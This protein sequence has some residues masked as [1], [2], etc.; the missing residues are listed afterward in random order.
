MSCSQ[1][2]YI[3]ERLS[4]VN[5][6]QIP[7]Y[8]AMTIVSSGADE[9]FV[10]AIRAAVSKI[11]M[12]RLGA[13]DPGLKEVL[14][15]LAAKGPLGAFRYYRENIL[16]HIG[17]T[18][19]NRLVNEASAFEQS[20]STGVGD[21]IYAALSEEQRQRYLPMHMFFVS[22]DWR[23]HDFLIRCDSMLRFHGRLGELWF[24]PARH[25]V[26][27]GDTTL[28]VCYGTH[29]I[30]RFMK[31]AFGA[32][33]NYA[34]LAA[35]HQTLRSE[36]YLES[37]TLSNGQPGIAAYRPVCAFRSHQHTYGYQY[38]CQVA[39]D[40]D[41][42]RDQCHL[43]GYCPLRPYHGFAIASTLLTPGFRGT[44]EHDSILQEVPD[45][46]ER[47]RMLQTVDRWESGERAPIEDA[48]L[49]RWFH[50]HGCPQVLQLDAS[51]EDRDVPPVRRESRTCGRALT[52]TPS[53]VAA[54][55]FYFQVRA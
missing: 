1:Q 49:L 34:S 7:P 42:R 23:N 22:I 3:N 41:D 36:L 37:L 54:P 50:A 35:I 9:E 44:P 19:T 28:T 11:R 25:K 17:T 14:K 20:I 51:R 47:A 4:I 13:V 15:R 2:N 29:T 10:G 24:S 43:L 52:W 5:R 26:S 46:S 33:R 38:L 32:E 55:D 53:A 6:I 40:P 18:S 39:G 8:P 27:V 30:E 31:R 48:W 16:C 21:L 12:H 45:E